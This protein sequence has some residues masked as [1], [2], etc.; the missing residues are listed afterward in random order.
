MLVLNLK[1]GVGKSTFT[2]NLASKLCTAQHCVELIDSD[3]QVSSHSWA[4]EIEQ[5]ETQQLNISFRGYSD[6]ASSVK[7]SKNCDFIIID[8][9]ANF[10]DNHIKKYLML[11]DFVVVPIQPSP[12]DLHATLP[13]IEKIMVNLSL[14]KK[15][16]QV[17]F[18]INRC[19][20]GN[21]QV[22]KVRDLLD[23]FQQYQTLGLM[24]DSY[25]YQ[26]PFQNKTIS[27]ISLDEPLWNNIFRWLGISIVDNKVAHLPVK[28]NTQIESKIQNPH[29]RSNI[30]RWRTVQKKWQIKKRT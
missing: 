16:V 1:G 17:G 19:S 14:I 25:L 13:L 22:K 29:H 20:E 18:I 11:A 23:H 12:V 10:D 28:L 6:I 9:P 24:T 2:V 30:S 15:N 27:K 26:E 7:V 4:K 5:I 3:K 21:P 8:S